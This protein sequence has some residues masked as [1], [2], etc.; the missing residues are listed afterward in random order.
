MGRI[1]FQRNAR[2]IGD[3]A[4]LLASL[5]AS[6]TSLV[7]FDPQY[8]AMLDKLKYGNEGER[9][10]GRASLPQMSEETIGIYAR[11]IERI[12]R[13]RR[14]V[15]YWMDKFSFGEGLHKRV[16]AQAPMLKMV[17]YIVWQKPRPGMG[18]RTRF[19]IEV[20]VIIQKEPTRARGFWSDRGIL[21]G[22]PEGADYGLHPHAKPIAL[23]TRLVRTLTRTRDLVVDPCA[24]GYTTL[25][26]CRATGR[27]FLGCDLINGE[28]NV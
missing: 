15:L 25:M 18:K 23:T 6:S 8:R 7:V 26:A 16:L 10:K 14:H 1:M 13:P 12:L 5:P 24:G 3:G 19:T 28:L 22:W 9:Q 4:D 11:E 21:D 27:E 2:N 17:D 20:M